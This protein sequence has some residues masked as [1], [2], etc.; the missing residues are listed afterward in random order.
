MPLD[1]EDDDFNSPQGNSTVCEGPLTSDVGE[2]EQL[3]IAADGRWTTLASRKS[4]D[5]W[6]TAE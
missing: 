4:R 6:E 2:G 3:Q 1:G 5:S